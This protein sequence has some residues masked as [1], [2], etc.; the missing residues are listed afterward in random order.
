M[1][2]LCVHV[3]M[4]ALVGKPGFSEKCCFKLVMSVSYVK[5]LSFHY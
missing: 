5:V 1:P 4:L 3:R 2:E